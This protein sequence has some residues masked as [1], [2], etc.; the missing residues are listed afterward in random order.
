[1][2]P[3]SIC[4]FFISTAALGAVFI[5]S[6]LSLINLEHQEYKTIT[7]IVEEAT[8]H[9]KI[10]TKV[11]V[12]HRPTSGRDLDSRSNEDKRVKRN[13]V[14]QQETIEQVATIIFSVALKGLWDYYTNDKKDQRS[15]R[16]NQRQAWRSHDFSDKFRAPLNQR[17]D[18]RAYESF[19]ELMYRSRNPKKDY[20][21]D[22]LWE[23][24]YPGTHRSENSSQDFLRRDYRADNRNDRAREEA[25]KAVIRIDRI[26]DGQDRKSRTS[27]DI[28][29]KKV[30]LGLYND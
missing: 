11:R 22:N 16:L 26:F 17:Q 12:E 18:H 3:R 14:N 20:Q 21:Y 8:P 13:A 15:H 24:R 9:E 30:K 2:K 4:L 27:R 19:D 6:L 7:N 25:A 1:M 10:A 5:V 28:W 23:L 29:S